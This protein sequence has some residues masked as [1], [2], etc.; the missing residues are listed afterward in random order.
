MA[1]NGKMV[2]LFMKAFLLHHTG[3]NNDFVSLCLFISNVFVV[4]L[5][6]AI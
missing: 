1:N 3:N 6:Q 2:K 5:L 4:H